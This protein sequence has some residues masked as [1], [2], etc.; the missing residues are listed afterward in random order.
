MIRLICTNCKTILE[1]DDGF[2]GGVCRCQHCGTIQTV[3]SHL[4][5]KSQQA[6]AVSK[7]LYQNQSRADLAGSTG[8]GL[9]ELADVVAS[10]GLAGSGLSSQPLTRPPQLD[11]AEPALK[12]QAKKTM[13]LMLSAAG[14]IVVLLGV[15]VAL[16]MRQPQTETTA[17]AATT[18][19]IAGSLPAASPARDA[20]APAPSST[21]RFCGIKLQ[22]N[23]IA[24]LLDRGDSTREA[25][26]ALKEAALQSLPTLG[27]DRRFQIVFWNNGSDSAYPS[28]LPAYAT[29]ENIAS[30]RRALEDLYAFGQTDVTSAVRKA[31]A[32]N[33][34][35]V[36]IATAK[37][38]QLDEDF[39]DK[40][41]ALRGDRPMRVH[42][43]AIGGSAGNDALRRLAARA[44]GEYREL[45]L[46]EL[47]N[48]GDSPDP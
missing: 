46:G 10:S 48:Y 22:G 21:A 34:S 39:A 25:F 42:T 38:W 16:L 13:V 47:S 17:S 15:V 6:A 44:G 36:V 18:G 23:S 31:L 20:A 41:L 30:A 11:L 24:Y 45:T 27:S 26:G 3:P 1:M 19:S 9:D 28:G 37:G 7:T 14:I 29:R 8:T 32:G 4:K 33:A 43:I 35:D 5:R 12:A 40:V 2:A